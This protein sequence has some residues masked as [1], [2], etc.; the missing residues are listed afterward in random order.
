MNMHT[1]LIVHW[2][3]FFHMC[4]QRDSDSNDIYI[5]MMTKVFALNEP[6]Q[7]PQYVLQM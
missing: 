7:N 5:K 6:K 2:E 3:S 1:D 4:L